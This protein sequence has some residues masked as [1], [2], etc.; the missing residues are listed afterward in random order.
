MS[1]HPSML[2]PLTFCLKYLV[3]CIL[4]KNQIENAFKVLLSV[5]DIFVQCYPINQLK[6]CE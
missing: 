1:F 6:G 5:A 2:T 4:N 3:P